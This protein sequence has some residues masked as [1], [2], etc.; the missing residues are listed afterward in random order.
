MGAYTYDV[1]S[2][3]EGVCKKLINLLKEG[4]F[5]GLGRVVKS[6]ENLEDVICKPWHGYT[7]P[8]ESRIP[9]PFMPPSTDGAI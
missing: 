3:K 8:G 7:G 5:V 4:R 1:F 2:K 9:P 6:P